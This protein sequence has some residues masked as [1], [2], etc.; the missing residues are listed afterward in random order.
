MARTTWIVML[1]DDSLECLA[2]DNVVEAADGTVTFR[3]E[4]RGD[5]VATREAAAYKAA[6]TADFP[7]A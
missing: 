6:W 3:T 4:I 1:A 5:V 2:A 7:R